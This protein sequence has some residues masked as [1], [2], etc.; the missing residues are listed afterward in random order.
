MSA[1]FSST[2]RLQL[3]GE[4]TF[5]DAARQVPYLADLGVTHLY[6]SPILQAVPGSQHGYDVVD[7]S[8]VSDEL[9]GEDGFRRLVAAAHEH[10][11]GVVVDVVPNHMA[12]VAPESLNREVWEVLRDGRDAATADWFDIDWKAG[13][14]RIGLPVLGE[15]LADVL[16]A[17]RLTLDEIDADPGTGQP[18]PV[19]RYYDHVYPVALGTETSGDVAEILERQHYRLASWR[20]KDDV[21]NYRRFF[22]VDGLIAV[23]VE[24]PE[25]FDA[26]HRLLLELHHEGLIDGFRID[27]PD[28]LA[29]PT[30][31]LERLAAACRPDTPVWV[32]KIL[33]GEE[34]LPRRWQTAGTTGYDALRVVQAAL[35][36]PEA[37]DTLDATWRAT[38]GE[39]DFDVVV[40]Q[41]K[42][43]VVEQSLAPEVE[44]LTRR[45]REA[46]PELDP[47]RL[48]EAVV[49]LLVAGEVYRAYVRPEHQIGQVA[50]RRLT[51]AFSAALTARPDLQ[52]ELDALLPVTVMAED[53]DAATDFG[54]RLQ[55]TWGP[56]MAKGIEDTSFYRWHRLIALNEVGSD[57]TVVAS[58]SPDL[59]HDWAQAQVEHWPRTMTT[60]TTHDTKRSEDVRA[61]L[62][63][64]AGDTQGWQQVSAVASAEAE[65]SGVDLPT[66]HLVWQTLLGVGE[67]GEER[68]RDYLQKALREGKQHTAWVDGD[69]DYERRVIDFAVAASTEG[70]LHDAVEELIASNA[71][72]IRATT[73][74]AKLLQLTLPGVPDTYQ[75]CETVSLSLVDPDNR[76]PV[77][78]AALSTA[79]DRGHGQGGLDTASPSGSAYSTSVGGSGDSTSVGGSGDSTSVGGSGDSTS[80]GGSASST[81][82]GGL[83]DEKLHLTSTV[84]QL[85]QSRAESLGP[86]GTYLPWESGD[87]H[88]AGF[89]RG[90]AAGRLAGALGRVPEPD[91]LVAVTR[92]PARLERDGGWGERLL[93]LPEGD[94]RDALDG[95]IIN[96]D[97]QIRARDLFADRPVAL[98][99]RRDS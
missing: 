68:L 41:A 50:R 73:L 84:L 29:D 17:G 83:G 37:A 72:A 67:I 4:F 96:S 94:W 66:G 92:A 7:H 71:N 88:A 58:A 36:D 14:G 3:H 99:E 53:S 65:R 11:L 90:P 45:A 26:T 16:A 54:V 59:M 63:A 78:Y 85:R 33:E 80:V 62:L 25:V 75:G 74:A 60:L 91:V 47:E 30:D 2:Y 42:R 86:G 21:L 8:R 5:D 10:D 82:L 70:P 61:R 93:T 95:R 18:A 28:G 24:L 44:R 76:R 57:P 35:T 22:E 98:L 77:D 55:Q 69:E 6:L 39:P 15:P 38:G 23:R 52:P 31:Y 19:L 13:G 34:R 97:G 87:E 12:F 43:Q 46:L 48:R 27:H 40:E 81:G 79:L 32:E 64:V 56:V 89:L 20:D 51:D 9:G 1:A 49:E